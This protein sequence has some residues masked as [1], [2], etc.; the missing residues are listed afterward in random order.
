MCD[1]KGTTYFRNSAHATGEKGDFRLSDV[2]FLPVRPAV[3]S[4]QG[5]LCSSQCILRSSQALFRSAVGFC[6]RRPWG[7]V[8]VGF[9]DL[10]A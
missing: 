8:S 2:H 9:R 3:G 10:G 5:I 1:G 4:S 7:F 6:E